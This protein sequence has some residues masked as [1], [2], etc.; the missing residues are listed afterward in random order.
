MKINHIWANRKEGRDK[1]PWA[2][3]MKLS[4]MKENQPKWFKSAERDLN[5]P[6][7]PNLRTF[8]LCPSTVNFMQNG[9]VVRNPAD[10]FVQKQDEDIHISSSVPESANLKYHYEEQFGEGFPFQ[11]GF[12]KASI[13]FDPF[14]R[15][16]ISEPCTMI[17]MPCWWSE[18]NNLIQAYHGIV[19]LKDTSTKLDF[20]INMQVKIPDTSYK[21]PAY[22]PL[23]QLFFVEMRRPEIGDDYDFVFEQHDTDEVYA[24]TASSSKEWFSFLK[25]FQVRS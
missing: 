1:H 8:K 3:R 9:F 15:L 17:I 10:F 25:R 4:P 24:K 6:E 2:E 19:D 5:D 20:L 14:Q 7:V 11:D 16:K 23:A 18:Y 22:A 12:L 13:K 21:I